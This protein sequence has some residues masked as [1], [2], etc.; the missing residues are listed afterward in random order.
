MYYKP[1]KEYRAGVKLDFLSVLPTTKV[2]RLPRIV[3]QSLQ[4]NLVKVKQAC[5]Q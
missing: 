2:L 4:V 5:P 1:Q 3:K